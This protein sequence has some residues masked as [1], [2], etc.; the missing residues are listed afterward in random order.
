MVKKSSILG[1]E[2]T[3]LLTRRDGPT[4]GLA[5]QLNTRIDAGVT[6]AQHCIKVIDGQ[7]KHSF[8]PCGI[9][10][11]A[12]F[13]PGDGGDGAGPGSG[14]SDGGSLGSGYGGGARGFRPRAATPD[15]PVSGQARPKG[16][17][18]QATRGEADSCTAVGS[19]LG[20]ES[21][22][23]LVVDGHVD[24]EYEDSDISMASELSSDLSS[25]SD[26]SDLSETSSV[27]SVGTCLAL[28]EKIDREE[29]GLDPEGSDITVS[30]SDLSIEAEKTV[31]S[32]GS[33]AEYDV[34]FDEIV[35]M[36]GGREKVSRMVSHEVDNYAARM[37]RSSDTES[38]KDL[39]IDLDRALSGVYPVPARSEL[40]PAI[41]G[42]SG[43]MTGDFAPAI[44]AVNSSK[45][46]KL[47]SS[48]IKKKWKSQ[49]RRLVRQRKAAAAARR[50]HTSTPVEEQEGSADSGLELT[51]GS[52]SLSPVLTARDCWNFLEE[53]V[54]RGIMAGA[55]GK[56]RNV[57]SGPDGEFVHIIDCNAVYYAGIV[58]VNTTTES[59]EDDAAESVA[60]DGN[61]D[62]E[63]DSTQ[64]TR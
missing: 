54:M 41:A 53:G 27:Y 24:T 5:F 2:N 10:G 25:L 20:L 60:L 6:R 59:E 35:P 52:P 50:R 61:Q 34:V 15:E 36:E 44:N 58:T 31:N 57:V 62:Q 12:N 48:F 47:T 63:Q 64:S 11:Q 43:A 32:S 1:A 46:R 23:E 37:N 13:P 42:A 33:E 7:A 30:G 45:R 28:L 9:N 26:L 38:L 17:Y 14:G 22:E 29:K 16:S 3:Q 56:M 49:E 39:A 40:S 21:G 19:D 4:G 8:P 51:Q 55:D 18:S